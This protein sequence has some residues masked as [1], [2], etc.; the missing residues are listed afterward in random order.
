MFTSNCLS[1]STKIVNI[2]EFFSSKAFYVTYSI[3]EA[4]IACF[5][6]YNFILCMQITIIR[7]GVSCEKV[8]LHEFDVPY[9]HENTAE[10]KIKHD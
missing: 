1:R 7:R 2:Q 3:N 8:L 6:L 5:D 10:G 4:S 9:N